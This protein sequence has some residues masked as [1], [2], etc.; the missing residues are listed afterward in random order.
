MAPQ[1][2][3]TNLLF[4]NHAKWRHAFWLGNPPPPSPWPQK[5]KPQNMV[6]AAHVPL[7]NPPPP[8]PTPS[9]S[10]TNNQFCC[11]EASPPYPYPNNPLPTP[12]ANEA[13]MPPLPLANPWPKPK[14][15]PIL[16]IQALLQRCKRVRHAFLPPSRQPPFPQPSPLCP[17][18][19]GPKRKK[20]QFCY[21]A[22]P[23]PSP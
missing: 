14:K 10:P 1:A 19:H 15:Q 8:P 18:P 23:Y 22:T 16:L 5:L 17:W 12:P 6:H 11:S 2:E 4:F 20:H 21:C 3:N 9:Q 13:H 7:A